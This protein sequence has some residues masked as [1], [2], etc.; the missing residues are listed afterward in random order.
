LNLEEGGR[1]RG[2]NGQNVCHPPPARPSYAFQG[3][4]RE[5]N[6]NPGTLHLEKPAREEEDKEFPVLQENAQNVLPNP[7]HERL[8]APRDQEVPENPEVYINQGVVEAAR[9]FRPRA[10]DLPAPTEPLNFLSQENP[11]FRN[12]QGNPSLDILPLNQQGR[13]RGEGENH[14][15]GVPRVFVQQRNRPVRILPRARPVEAYDG[16]DEND[17]PPQQPAAHQNPSP[18]PQIPVFSNRQ[19]QFPAH[20]AARLH[21]LPQRARAQRRA[22]SVEVDN[23]CAHAEEAPPMAAPASGPHMSLPK[24]ELPVF[25]GEKGAKAH[26]W[27]ESLGRFQKNYRMTDEQAVEL[28]RFSCKGPYAKAWAGL[29]PEDLTLTTFKEHFKAKVAVEN[30]DRLTSELLEKVQKKGVGE[31]ATEMME[32]FKM[33]QL[34]ETAK[35]RHFKCAGFEVWY[36]GNC[37]GIGAHLFVD[38]FEKG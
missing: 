26:I 11:P 23:P 24:L 32:Y 30:Q 34:D 35:I 18:R 25:K 33:L 4:G 31:Y 1:P 20:L 12:H 10:S 28:A 15:G 22:A 5:V 37:A 8:D 2:F 7:L 16:D 19:P 3:E 29:L 9:E 21:L 13:A 14:E 6:E 38:G 17:P 36:E 27:L